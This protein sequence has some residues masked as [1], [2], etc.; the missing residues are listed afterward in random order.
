[1]RSVF[2]LLLLPFLPANVS[3]ANAPEFAAG[4]IPIQ[5]LDAKRGWDEIRKVDDKIY[6]YLPKGVK[7]SA[8][9]NTTG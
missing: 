2:I 8:W 1:M 5:K 6:L 7:A 9:K 3:A 4:W